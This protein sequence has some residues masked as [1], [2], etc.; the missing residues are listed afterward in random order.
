MIEQTAEVTAVSAEFAQVRVI[1]ETTCG[2]CQAQKACGTHALSKVLGNRF[3][4]VTALNKV[5]AKVGDLVEIGL[6]ESVLLKSAF[7]VYVFPLAMFFVC[8]VIVKMINQELNL[9]FN[10]GLNEWLVI[11]GGFLGFV[12]AF[13]RVKK[14]MRHRMHDERYQ[15]VIL[16]PLSS[17]EH[18]LKT[19]NK[20]VNFVKG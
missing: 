19:E 1:R 3:T 16:R 12:F 6:S 18:D 10:S 5:G 9:G 14:G 20:S 2:S 7:L 11:A 13:A 8:A 4:E 15:P 17:N